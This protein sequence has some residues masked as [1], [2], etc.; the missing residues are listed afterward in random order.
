MFTA[1]DVIEILGQ[2]RRLK[3]IRP[4]IPG[5]L[6]PGWQAWLDAMPPAEGGVTG[7]LPQAFVDEL[8]QRP[9]AQP[10]RRMAQLNRWQAFGTLWRQQWQPPMR[11]E[12]GMRWFAA[13]FSGTLHCVLFL[14]L[15]WLAYVRIEPPA[16]AAAE[17]DNVV[18][19]EFIGRGTP[20]EQ[21]GGTPAGPTPE[22]AASAASRA[23]STQP[24][25]SAP[26]PS[27]AASAPSAGIRAN[28]VRRRIRAAA[29]GFRTRSSAQR[30]CARATT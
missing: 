8:A 29:T 5:R 18:Q 3:S 6:P 13:G 20:E 2:R 14:M 7:A 22:P 17:G 21:G 11:E 12:R 26:T 27:D 28:A 16:P 25:T 23:A 1:A 9:L 10:P 15:L 24:P 4:D 30:R 19:V